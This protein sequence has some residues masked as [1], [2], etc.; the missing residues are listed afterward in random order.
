MTKRELARELDEI[1]KELQNEIRISEKEKICYRLKI[2]S[3]LLNITD[4][5]FGSDAEL[6]LLIA[7][8][9]NLLKVP[10]NLKGYLYLQEMIFNI[11]KTPTGARKSL[12]KKIEN[13]YGIGYGNVERSIRT[14]KEK[15][16]EVGNKEM[17]QTLFGNVEKIPINSEF[18]AVLAEDIR[19][20]MAKY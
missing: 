11:L 12:Y 1:R 17:L 15:V 18:V 10:R 6:R 8:Y 13:K 19:T 3:S 5:E 4:K 14:A 2:L 20:S 16:F 7:D 9:L